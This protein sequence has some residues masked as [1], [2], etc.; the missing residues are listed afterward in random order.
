MINIDSELTLYERFKH[1]RT[2]NIFQCIAVGR[3]NVIL[4]LE[5]SNT[6]IKVNPYKFLKKFIRL[7][8]YNELHSM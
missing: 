1:K 3:K 4:Q 5:G 7:Y 8:N 6:V 2:S